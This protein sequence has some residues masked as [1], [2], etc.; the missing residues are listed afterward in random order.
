MTEGTFVVRVTDIEAGPLRLRLPITP[1]WLEQA[2]SDTEARPWL[3]KDGG[4][5]EGRLAVDIHMSG[6]NVLVRGHVSVAVTMPCARTLDPANYRFEPEVFLMLAPAG[7]AAVGQVG[8]GRSVA[9]A[10]GPGHGLVGQGVR[11]ESKR[12]ARRA[13]AAEAAAAAPAKSAPAKGAPA[14]GAPAKGAKGKK[15]GDWS[16]DPELA[17]EDAAVDTYSGE[18]IVLDDFIREFILLELPMFPER[19]DLRSESFE[20]SSAPPDGTQVTDASPDEGERPLD[21]RLSPLA[22]LK[23]R[24]E[25][26]ARLEKKE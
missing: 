16:E 5:D 11:S 2:L 18:Q 22:D 6:R 15:G 17:E 8:S 4:E 20:G 3:A 13:A 25:E 7:H 1:A 10:H 26:R 14:K 9:G 12:K 19:E 21:P 23:A 24:L